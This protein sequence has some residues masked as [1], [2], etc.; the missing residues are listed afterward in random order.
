MSATSEVGPVMRTLSAYIAEALPRRLPPEVTEKGKHHL[1]D[2]LAAMVSG[3][4]LPPGRLA[5]SYVRAQGGTPEVLVVGSKI[6][7]SAVNAALAGGMLAHADETDD[8]HAPSFSHPGCAVV[9]AALAMAERDGR[10]GTAL[11]RAV[12]LGYD[13]GCRATQALGPRAIYRAGRSSHSLAGLFGAAA[14]AGALAALN[15]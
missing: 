6:L 12:V 7:T 9:P 13:V 1:L 11:L 4:R 2:T 8:S 3:S 10:D 15:A 5:T 14:A